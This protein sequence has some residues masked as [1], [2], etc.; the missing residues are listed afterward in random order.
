MTL[1]YFFLNF[2]TAHFFAQLSAATYM[3]NANLFLPIPIHPKA[4]E[5]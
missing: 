1:I 4:Y 5:E 2:G 3:Y